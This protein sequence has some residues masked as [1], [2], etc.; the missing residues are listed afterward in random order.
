M[1]V[2]LGI[3]AVYDYGRTKD[4]G[5]LSFLGPTIFPQVVRVSRSLSH[6]KHD[7]NSRC[8]ASGRTATAVRSK[9]EFECPVIAVYSCRVWPA[10]V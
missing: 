10:V 1:S 9:G 3:L 2:G 8:H 6:M 5:S 4:Q 7:K